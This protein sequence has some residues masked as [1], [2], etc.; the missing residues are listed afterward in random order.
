MGVQAT[1]DPARAARAAIEALAGSL[2]PELD[3]HAVA[4]AQ[5][6][7]DGIEELSDE[8]HAD[9]VHSC[10]ANIGLVCAMLRDGEPA[11]AARPPGEA[12][13]Y[14]REFVR[15]GLPIEALMR[16]YRIGHQVFW[17]GFVARLQ[18]AVQDHDELAAAVSLASDWTF[19]YV[20]AVSAGIAEAYMAEREQWVRSAAALRAEVV[21]GILEARPVDETDASRRLR[22]EL[23][24]RHVG[25]VIWGEEAA[26]KDGTI[27]AFERLAAQVAATLGGAKGDVLCVPLGGLVL[28]CWAGLRDEPDA[29][30]LTNL[31][32]PEAAEHSARIAVGEPHDGLDG[33]R[34]SHEEA[35][36]AR[37]VGMLSRRQPGALVRYSDAALNALL[38]ADLD[39]ARRFARRELGDLAADDDASRR[40][41]ATLKVFFEEGASFV[42]AAR[43]L[44][45][46]ENTIAYRVRRA[47]ELLGHGV[48]ARQLEV[49]VALQVAEILRKAGELDGATAATP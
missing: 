13:H 12:L 46:H 34:R 43:R 5:E 10:R 4:M 14:A 49:R 24:R 29:G 30:A 45:V 22:Y 19:A 11:A 27:G 41:A 44:G 3:E 35:M 40:L 23:R 2:V 21:R 6:I 20:D 1:T 7:H 38:T 31:A 48:D 9:T 36:L 47:G 16:T 15:R 37:R 18:Q 39:A 42:K 28:A 17:R 32:A 25:F 8:L 33:F 26:E